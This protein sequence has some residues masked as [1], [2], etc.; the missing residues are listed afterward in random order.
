MPLLAAI[1]FSLVGGVAGWLLLNH[2]IDL[3]PES[4]PVAQ[5]PRRQGSVAG[6]TA[7][8]FFFL[9]LA[10][11]PTL[12]LL[13]ATLY[14]CL[15][16][17]VAFID[18]EHRLILNRVIYPSLVAAVPLSL[19]HGNSL[20]SVLIGGVLGFGLLFVLFV[21]SRGAIGAGDV[22][23]CGVV[24]LFAG[25]PGVLTALFWASILAGIIAAGLLITKRVRR[26]DFIPYGPFICAGAAAQV[27]F[28]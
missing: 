9:G 12:A 27:L 17:V 1:A 7:A 23:L 18:L 20:G 16:V 25:F 21:V 15:L 8:C 22:K 2:S 19:L 24:G 28:Y 11:G 5:V 6:A 13:P 3:L 4:P 10:F 26:G 14:V